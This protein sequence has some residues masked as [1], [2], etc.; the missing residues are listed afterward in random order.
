MAAIALNRLKPKNLC[1]RCHVR[2]SSL[3]KL[4]PFL[5]HVGKQPKDKAN[6][7]QGR[8]ERIQRNKA[9][10]EVENFWVNHWS[11]P[12]CFWAFLFLRQ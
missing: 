6:T 1:G 12:H 2:M 7:E 3:K 11:S 5:P 10:E 4:Q 9:A 8:A